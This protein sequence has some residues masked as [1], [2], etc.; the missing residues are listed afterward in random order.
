MNEEAGGPP[1]SE[2]QPAS[3]PLQFETAEGLVPQAATCASC[4]NVL[5][6]EYHELNGHPVCATCRARAEAEY[7]QDQQW[8]RFTAAVAYGGGAALIGALAYWAFVKI[9]DFEFGLMAIGVGW[10]VGKAVMKGSNLRGGRRYQ[11]LAIMLTY[12][13]ITLSYGALIFE[14]LWKNP[15]KSDTVKVVEQAKGPGPASAAG[16]SNSPG[17]FVGFGSLLLLALI[18]PFLSGFS[19]I[20]GWVI[21]AI[22]LFE[23][24]KQTRAVPFSAAGPF[25]LGVKT[26][27]A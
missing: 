16:D 24:W 23:A 14:Q 15:P 26:T 25:P 12:L 19:N 11:Y 20:I 5:S 7:Q 4:A 21:I 10:L 6:G 13:S 1:E 8:S 9:A 2:Q 22:G 27:N 18:S 17:F 3:S